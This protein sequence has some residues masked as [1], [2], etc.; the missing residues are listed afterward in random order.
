MYWGLSF[1]Q[2]SIVGGDF[3]VWTGNLCGSEMKG[4]R[5]M[6]GTLLAIVILNY[7]TPGLTSELV[8]WF[9]RHYPSYPL[10]VVDNASPDN[11]YIKLKDMLSQYSNVV[12]LE[13]DTNCGYAC[14]NNLGVKY[15]IQ[16][17]NPRYVM[18]VNPDVRLPD[19][20]IENMIRYLEQ[21]SQL[22]MV[23]GIMIL[24]GTVDF[25]SIAWKLPKRFDDVFLNSIL[26]KL[27]Y[28]P[29]KY[30]K[31][32]NHSNVLPN[33]FYVDVIPGSCFIIRSD[34]FKEVGY[35]DEGTF[36]YAE[37]RILAN[38]VKR[39]GFKVGLSISDY[40]FHNHS[41]NNT[42]LK[43]GLFHLYHLYRSRLYYNIHYNSPWGYLSL[44]FF[45]GSA[46]VGMLEF[47]I[48][49]L[50]RKLRKL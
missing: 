37:E 5:V 3:R 7:N 6:G 17:F 34:V 14:G 13:N 11:S 35:F 42:S 49:H 25:S 40:Y 30:S 36:L 23:T 43:R 24:N 20:F 18:I 28:N 41:S 4:V 48:V 39:L 47:V 38:K 22:A 2:G 12:I 32:T 19:G 45:V 50:L 21:D 27:L 1:R 15:A 31:L 9:V 46:F 10:I 44:P 33:V 29:C 8:S 26:L 16:K